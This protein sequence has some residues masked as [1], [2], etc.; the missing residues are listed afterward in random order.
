[1]S[2]IL[3]SSAILA[4]LWGEVGGARAAEALG[5]RRI[6]AVD[7]TEAVTKLSERGGD[8]VQAEATFRNLALSVVAFDERQAVSAGLFSRAT[9]S[10]GL[11]HGHRACLAPASATGFPA[12]TAD[13]AWASLGLGVAVEVIR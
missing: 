6:S 4:L 2:V 1:M 5:S 13:R 9:R 7:A 11:S 3:D 8:P 10:V 12:L